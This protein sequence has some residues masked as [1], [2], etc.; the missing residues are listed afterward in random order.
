MVCHPWHW[1][2][3]LHAAHNVWHFHRSHIGR[4]VRTITKVL[5]RVL[6]V[7]DLT[8]ETKDKLT[9]AFADIDAAKTADATAADSAAA[10]AV[11]QTKVS[12]DQAAQ[13]AAHQQSTASSD[14]ALNAVATDLGLPVPFP[15]S[16]PVTPPAA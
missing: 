11:A 5:R 13:N 10:L 3:L 8:Q 2:A 12:G 16:P 6:P 14:D 15:V 4:A 1:A 9:K 7:A